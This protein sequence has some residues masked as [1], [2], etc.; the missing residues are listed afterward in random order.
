MMYIPI[1]KSQK[2]FTSKYI[3]N[4]LLLCIYFPSPLCR[5]YNIKKRFN[6]I[7]LFGVKRCENNF[8]CQWCM[9]GG[10]GGGVFLFL[11]WFRVSTPPS[12]SWTFCSFVAVMLTSFS[13][14]FFNIVY[15]VFGEVSVIT[16][17]FFVINLMYLFKWL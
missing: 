7:H 17:Q 5:W 15:I 3:K 6:T 1:H 12:I 2:L 11:S 10:G 13:V 14:V 9:V 8:S 4:I 16:S